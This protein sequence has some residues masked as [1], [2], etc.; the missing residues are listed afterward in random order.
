M[1]IALPSVPAAYQS[2]W[3]LPLPVMVVTFCILWSA[4]FAVAKV[5]VVAPTMMLAASTERVD[6]RTTFA[7]A[8]CALKS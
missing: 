5:A 6:V 8:G 2:T 4:A 1:R 7:P 3:T